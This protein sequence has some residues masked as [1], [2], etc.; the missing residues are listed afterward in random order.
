MLKGLKLQGFFLTAKNPCILTPIFYF[1][2]KIAK[3]A[4]LF[5]LTSKSKTLK[6]L[7]LYG[8]FL[9]THQEILNEIKV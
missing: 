1:D 9:P 2:P 8:L 7:K 6:I 3:P 4:F 5:L